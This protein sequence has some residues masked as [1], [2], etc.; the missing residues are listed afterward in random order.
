[1]KTL[2]LLSISLFLITNLLAQSPIHEDSIPGSGITYQYGPGSPNNK[3]WTYAYGVKL[4]VWSTSYRNFEI[5]NTQ[6]GESSTLALRTFNGGGSGWTPWREFLFKDFEGHMKFDVDDYYSKSQTD[7][8]GDLLLRSSN[9]PSINSYGAALSFSKIGGGSNKRS[10]IVAKQTGTDED[11]VG[12]AFLTHSNTAASDL[13]ERM[14]I[15]GNGNVGIGTIDPDSRLSVNGTIHSKEVKVDLDGWSDHVF[16]QDYPLMDLKEVSSYIVENQHLPNIPTETE[17][18]ENG[19][20]LGEMNAKL[21]EKIEE[22][23]LYL[24]EQN[25]ELKELRQEIIILKSK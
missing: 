12:L 13:I 24:I 16:R 2:I 23:T 25:R 7:F 18:K 14:I 11:N 10:S 21:L 3:D 5:M 22:L 4:S 6:K 9:S 20:N 1:M 19:I 15:S 8:G 17:V